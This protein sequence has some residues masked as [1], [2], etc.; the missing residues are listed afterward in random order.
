MRRLLFIALLVAFALPSFGQSKISLAD[1]AKAPGTTGQT[2]YNNGGVPAGVTGSSVSGSKVTYGGL[3]DTQ[4]VVTFSATP[5]FDASAA[6]NFKITLTANVTSSTLSNIVAGQPIRF[7]I[8]QDSTGSRTFVWP[9]NIKGAGTITATLSVCSSQTFISDGTNAYASSQMADN[10][11]N[12]GVSFAEGTGADVPGASG[13]DNIHGDSTAHRLQMNNN[14]AGWTSIAGALDT[15]GFFA[16][17]SS[18]TFFGVIN[19]ETGSGLVVGNNTPLLVTPKVTTINDANGN[20]FITSSATASAVDS[21]TVTNAATANPATVTVGA[22]GSDTNVNLALNAKGTGNVQI[23]PACTNAGFVAYGQGTD[24]STIPTTSIL[25]QAPTSVTSYRITKPGAKPTNNHSAQ[26]YSNATPG[27]GAWEKLQQSVLTTTSYTNATTTFSTVT[28]TNTLSFAVEAS[29]SYTGECYILWQGS[30]S[31][32]GPKFQFTGPASPTAFIASVTSNVTATTISTASATAFSSA[33]ANAGT[34]TATTN[35]PAYITF[36]LV[37]GA[38][39]G[40]VTLQAAAN[41]TGTLTIQPGSYCQ[42]Q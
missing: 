25:E 12:G 1:Q 33:M 35:F 36:S 20:P 30:A 5:T 39:A 16:A 38:N 31:T 22:S 42:L 27:V 18:S 15:L 34:V 37:N 4:T 3:V 6:N 26:S 13:L 19:D 23:C 40:T 10:G 2:I 9:T 21:I 29:T 14:N 8:C 7:T 11:A 24:N 28:G 41:G 17:T 32:T